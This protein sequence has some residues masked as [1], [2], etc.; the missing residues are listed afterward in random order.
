MAKKRRSFFD[1]YPEEYDI[2]TNAKQRE[3]YHR[4]EVR[5]IADE[6]EPKSVM[7]AG[8]A[9]GLTSRLFAE[10]GISTVG[11]DR[12]K[13]MLEIARRN[14]STNNK[15]LSY[16]YGTF[17]GLPKKLHGKFELVVCLANAIAGVGTMKMLGQSLRNFRDVLSP[18]GTLLIQMLNY[19][20]LR[21]GEIMPV[22]ATENNGIVLERFSE[23]RGKRLYLY[24]TRVDLKS[25]NPVVEV[26]RSEFDNFTPK[27][28][29]NSLKKVG[30]TS[31]RR[32][33]DLYLKKP[34]SKSS[35]DLVITAR[36]AD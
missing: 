17:E 23:R 35:R 22:R 21:E 25:D 34:F 14:G 18:G 8:C 26:F 36:R 7:D 13:P 5:A 28:V 24:V 16:M 9:T 3:G 15:L 12:A 31:I 6:F 10:L 4:K 29:E 20:A 19:A 33:N 32:Y 11:L 1:V 2:L 27:E 30:F